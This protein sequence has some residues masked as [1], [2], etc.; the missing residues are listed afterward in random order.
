MKVF[1]KLA[2]AASLLLGMATTT[3][4]ADSQVKPIYI[5]GFSAS[6]NDSTVYF[7]DIQRMDSAW[8]EKK[9]NFLLGRENFSYQLR[10]YLSESMAQPHRTCIVIYGFSQKDINKKLAELKKKYISKDKQTYDVKYLTAED[11]SF[12]YVDMSPAEEEVAPQPK[13]P[14]DKKDKKDNKDKKRPEG[15]GPAGMPPGGMGQG[16][17]PM[18]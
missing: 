13:A 6:F 7:T 1:G 5:F 2:I 18:Q 3:K 14:K 4:A 10:D 11:F 16:R 8:I 9:T 17:P 12:K 15:K